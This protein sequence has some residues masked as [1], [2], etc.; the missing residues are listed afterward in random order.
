MVS[1]RTRDRLTAPGRA[2]RAVSTIRFPLDGL[3]EGAVLPQVTVTDAG[4]AELPGSDVRL[5]P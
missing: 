1:Q 5:V 4:S 3:P 2:A